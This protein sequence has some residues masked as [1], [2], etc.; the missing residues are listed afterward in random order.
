L[1]SYRADKPKVDG[2]TDR[3]TDGG[4]DITPS[5]EVPRGK[6]HKLIPVRTMNFCTSIMKCCDQRSD[7]WCEKVKL[8][9]TYVKDLPAADVVYHNIC[10]T[11]FRNGKQIPQCFQNDNSSGSN[12]KKPKLGRPTDSEKRAAFL[13][14][15]EHLEA[16]DEEQTTVND[17]ILRMAQN[18]GQ[19]NEPYSFKYMKEMLH[20]HFGENIV[21]TDIS[22]IANVVTFRRKAASILTKF[23]QQSRLLDCELEK[24]RVVETAASLIKSDIKSVLQSKDVYPSSHQ[25]S[26][27]TDN[28]SYL[29]NTL[30]HFLDVLLVGKE[31]NVK[32]GSI[33]QALM[34]ATRPK[35]LLTPLQLGLGVQM[36]HHFASRCL[37]DTL[38]QH[39]FCCSY[40]EVQRYER[41]AAISNGVDIPG[42]LP[43]HF[44]Q[45]VADNVDH[46][47]R[48]LD[49]SGT[50]HGMGI[51]AAITPKIDHASV[52]KRM[53]VSAKDIAQ[54]GSINIRPFTPE[55]DG[56]AR[57]KFEKF[58]VISC[59]D[60]F[61]DI[62]LLWKLSFYVRPQ[63]PG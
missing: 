63:T 31:K 18:L 22:G 25:M 15:V 19:D 40:S 14:V 21:I 3:R 24:L 29:P 47:I 17:L 2:R 43:G 33:G 12:P 13:S 34:Q 7:E 20:E 60:R 62:D 52:I 59:K 48:T 10:S 27:T 30:Q 35:V 16:N 56:M 41:S 6:N 4:N 51:L 32:V 8:R 11:N 9:L 23:F 58:E 57:L 28:L 38:Y 36:H 44:M 26:N 49:G 5:A 53:N 39:G 54:V 46:N 1:T 45:Y 50:F 42:F 55:G 37:L 61:M